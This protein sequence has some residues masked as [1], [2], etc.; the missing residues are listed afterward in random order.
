MRAQGLR[1]ARAGL[2]ALGAIAGGLMFG[3]VP[4]L[5]AP[6][7]PVTTSPATSITHSSAVLEGVLNPH[8]VAEAGWYFAY[9][10]GAVCGGAFSTG[11]GEVDGEAVAEH[12]EA[13]GLEPARK[14]VFCLVATNE[15]G[16]F[17]RG[18][19]ASFETSPLAPE[20][21]KGSESASG[22][23]PF[24]VQ[25]GAVL[26][27]NN[28]ETHYSFEYSTAATGETLEGT[29]V[30]IGGK[31]AI[32]PLE[33]GGRG[34]GVSGGHALE[35]AKMYFYRVVAVNATG[36]A[37]GKVESFTTPA[38]TAPLVASETASTRSTTASVAATVN[39]DHQETTCVVQ[40]LTEAEFLHSG[41]ATPESVPCQPSG[42]GLGEGDAPVEVSASL[43]G[44]EPA[45]VYH[46]RVVATDK[47]GETKSTD[48]TFR[49]HVLPPSATTGGTSEVTYNTAT[50]TGTV[51]PGSTGTGADTH[52]CVQYGTIEDGS[53]YDLGS[54][55][56][57][58]GDAGEGTSP[59]A[60]SMQLTGLE[61][62]ATY[63]YRLVAVNALGESLESIA[64]GTEGGQETDGAEATVTTPGAPPPPLATTGPAT[65]V[66]QNAATISGTIDPQGSRTSYEFQ[67]GL[68]TT[69]GA[70]VY[71]EAGEGSEPG[72]FYLP[73]AGLQPETTYHYRIV[74]IS[75]N[76]STVYG[77][78]ETFAT[79][80]YPTESLIPPGSAPLI[81][82]PVFAFPAPVTETPTG[83]G[84]TKVKKKAKKKARKKKA[85]KGRKASTHRH[86]GTRRNG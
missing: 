62:G 37:K 86:A 85:G 73:L 39:P 36:T 65:A 18:N 42:P 31:S 19:E 4:V 11:G 22:V 15:R 55:P 75:S 20:V 28:E 59:V 5:A 76:G 72:T 32:P 78:D 69:Y 51:I 45:T 34:V 3:A 80:A 57:L 79:T 2:V 10:P 23:T 41:Y 70:Q 66:A 29:I 12:A 58:S 43:T 21:I 63:R 61:P 82:T 64:C 47:T 30:T 24:E 44:L 35:P 6:E 77:V 54:L 50:V 13:T 71:G 46:Y 17:T 9:S 25:L 56:L 67:L 16:E 52:W 81:P 1:R 14:Y 26:N 60:V 27:A 74:A 68:D 33:F 83:A 8:A 84:T 49:T 53:E 40:Y 38:A 48:A 7:A